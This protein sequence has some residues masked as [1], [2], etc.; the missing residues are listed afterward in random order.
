MIRFVLGR[1]EIRRYGHGAGGHLNVVP[2][3][4]GAPGIADAL[5][6][7]AVAPNQA[8]SIYLDGEQVEALLRDLVGYFGLSLEG[9]DLYRR[10]GDLRIKEKGEPVGAQPLGHDFSIDHPLDG[11]ERVL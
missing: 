1:Q 4:D 9:L 3:P 5:L 10:H 2:R 8:V 6:L 7:E 11:R